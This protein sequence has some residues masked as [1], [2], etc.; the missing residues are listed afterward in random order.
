MRTQ[1][2]DLNLELKQINRTLRFPDNV[3]EDVLKR[4]LERKDYIKKICQNIPLGRIGKLEDL[5]PAGIRSSNFPILP[6]G[7]FWHI[8]FM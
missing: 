4:L 1:L 2:T 5:I 3:P 8:F 7:I 6:S